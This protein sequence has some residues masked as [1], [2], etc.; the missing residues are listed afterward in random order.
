MPYASAQN[1]D[2]EQFQLIIKKCHIQLSAVSQ[3]INAWNIYPWYNLYII[4]FRYQPR[5]SGANELYQTGHMLPYN[6]ITIN[7]VGLHLIDKSG[8]LI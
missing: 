7:I 1:H 4:C 5:P 3:E 8:N 6:V 2:L